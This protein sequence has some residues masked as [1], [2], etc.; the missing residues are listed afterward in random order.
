MANQ[1]PNNMEEE[2]LKGKENKPQRSNIIS[3]FHHLKIAKEYWDDLKREMPDTDAEKLAERYKK[4]I[5]WCYLDFISIPSFPKE[6]RD[7]LRLEWNSDALAIPEIMNTISL[8]TPDNRLLI[9]E[10]SK[11]LL[12]GEDITFEQK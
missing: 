9:E 1:R 2:I 4:K 7:G 5:D 6:V 10:I 12:A 3:A 8:L 11:A